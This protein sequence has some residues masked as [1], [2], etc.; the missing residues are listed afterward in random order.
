[1]VEIL[2]AVRVWN[3]QRK[4]LREDMVG[5]KFPEEEKDSEKG[6]IILTNKELMVLGLILAVA[7]LIVAWVSFKQV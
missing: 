7:S 5:N 3:E 2:F 6:G 4:S 1:M